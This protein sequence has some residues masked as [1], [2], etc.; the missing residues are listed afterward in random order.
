MAT[1]NKVYRELRQIGLLTS[2]PMILLIAPLIG[3]FI[4]HWVDR[5]FASGVIFTGFFTLLGFIAAAR[6]ITAIIQRIS[7]ENGKKT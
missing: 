3:F 2:I 5:R 4:G 7:R 6:E 1:E